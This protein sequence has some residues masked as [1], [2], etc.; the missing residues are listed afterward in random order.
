M[1]GVER[2][3]PVEFAVVEQ[4]VEE[5]IGQGFEVVARV[6]RAVSVEVSVRRVGEILQQMQHAPELVPG[7]GLVASEV[8]GDRV[9]V[10]ALRVGPR[11]LGTAK[12]PVGVRIPEVAQEVE[13]AVL[14][15]VALEQAVAESSAPLQA[16]PES[17]PS[18]LS[19]SAANSSRRGPA[20]SAS[21]DRRASLRWLRCS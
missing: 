1:V 5:L 11:G 16:N 10:D 20:G 4:S 15:P 19:P 12:A 13:V 9:C 14:F 3:E 6:R 8:E 18:R 7:R 21:K 17:S 2:D